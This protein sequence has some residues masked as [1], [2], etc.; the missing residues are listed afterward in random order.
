MAR[1]KSFTRRNRPLHDSLRRT[2]E[3]HGADYVVEVPRS[4][5]WTTVAPGHR[6]D[7]EHTFGRRAPLVVEIGP[8]VGEQLVA[9]ARRWPDRDFLGLEVWQ[10]GIAKLVSRAVAAGVDNIRVVEADAAQALPVLLGEATVDEVW[11][12]FPDPWRKARHHK[13]RLVNAAFAEEVARV[14]VDGGAWR[15]ATDWDDYAWQMRD[16]VEACPDL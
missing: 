5:G 15:L 13:R 9:A 6:L 4:E 11:T 3:A 10:P 14:L 7:P 16:V 8:G 1:T 2:M 12:F